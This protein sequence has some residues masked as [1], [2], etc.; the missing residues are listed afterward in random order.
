[1]QIRN[2]GTTGR[3]AL[4]LALASL[5]GTAHA[6]EI[7][8]DTSKYESAPM[9]QPLAIAPAQPEAITHVVVKGDTLAVI[10]RKYGL[11]TAILDQGW[12]GFHRQLDYK[13]FSNGG[14][15]ITVRGQTRPV[16][17]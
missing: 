12:S 15:L 2:R 3:A 11:N 10:A 13:L 9:A 7:I 17:L 16:R 6:L 4:V 1:M 14:Y 5:W 8:P